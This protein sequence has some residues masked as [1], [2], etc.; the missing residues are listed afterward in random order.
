MFTEDIY[1][2][3]YTLFSTTDVSQIISKVPVKKDVVC[4]EG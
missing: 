2:C 3:P 1:I 4:K